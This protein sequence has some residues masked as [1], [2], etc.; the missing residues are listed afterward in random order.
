MRLNARKA[1]L[2]HRLRQAKSLANLTCQPKFPTSRLE[3]TSVINQ[4]KDDACCSDL[5]A[6][7]SRSGLHTLTLANLHCR[8]VVDSSGTHAFLDLPSHGEE[9]LF[10]VGSVLCRC[11][12][13]WN[14]NA[15]GKFL[16]NVS[17]FPIM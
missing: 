11:L 15:V 13:E 12:E 5:T 10:D 17:L 9:S 14:A 7:T 3:N 2:K 8:F 4:V 6:A 1:A 16:Q